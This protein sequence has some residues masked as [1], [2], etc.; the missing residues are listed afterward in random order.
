MA[1]LC[2]TRGT[3][4]V[5]LTCPY[6]SFA[7]GTRGAY[8]QALVEVAAERGLP[9]LEVSRIMNRD[10]PALFS[11]PAHPSADGHRVIAA[12]LARIIVAGGVLENVVSSREGSG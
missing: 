9:L 4:F 3:L 7:P 11:D 6:L 5:P 10:T 1:D 12:E 8:E 2:A